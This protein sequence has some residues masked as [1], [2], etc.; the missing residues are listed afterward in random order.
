MGTEERKM[1]HLRL[2][3]SGRVDLEE[4]WFDLVEL[5]PK[6]LPEANMDDIDTSLE[7]LGKKLKAPMIIEG[8]T[9]G[10]RGAERINRALAGAAEKYGLGFMVGSQ[11]AGME[12]PS[13]AYT[14]QV[15]DIFSGL[16]IANVGAAQVAKNGADFAIKA[17]EMIEADAVAIHV[18]P[19]QEALQ[20]EGDMDWRGAIREIKEVDVPV[21]LKGTGEGIDRFT[22]E[23][24]LPH[25]SG[26]DVGGR[27]GT[28]FTLVEHLRSGRGKVF[29][30]WGIPTPANVIWLSDLEIPVISSGGVRSGLDAVKSIVLGAAAA[31]MARPFLSHLK[32]LDSFVENLLWEIRVSMFLLGARELQ[33]LRE[34]PYI[35][36]EPLKSYVEGLVK[37]HK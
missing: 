26:V 19:G 7:L 4:K 10:F 21:I 14:Y 1:E 36:L 15:R 25:L 18:N 6:S 27:G 22:V 13:L 20:P 35:L 2:C 3:A 23:S 33:D 8:M 37:L 9:G 30:K 34:K 17:F 11:R 16:L 12:D 5:V 24:L 29:V 32:D 28:S 31:G